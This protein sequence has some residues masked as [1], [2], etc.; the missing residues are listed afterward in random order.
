VL[1]HRESD[2]PDDHHRTQR[3]KQDAEAADEQLH[4]TPCVL[5]LGQGRGTLFAAVLPRKAP[6]AALTPIGHQ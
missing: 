4:L 3:A 6:A 2:R 5:A 1:D